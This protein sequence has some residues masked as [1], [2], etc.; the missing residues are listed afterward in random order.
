MESPDR[1]T[2][3][4][5]LDMIDARARRL[6]IGRE[7]FAVAPDVDL[8]TFRRGHRVVVH[9]FRN[10]REAVVLGIA[11][12]DS[13]RT[14]PD[15]SEV[16]AVVAMLTGVLADLSPE[17]SVI[18]CVWLPEDDRYAVRLQIPR[19]AGKAILIPRRVLDRAR[20][21]PSTRRTL[22]NLLHA[23][24]EALRAVRGI[25]E[26]RITWYQSRI[27]GGIWAG[28]RC[29]RCEG[30]LLPDDPVMSQAGTRHHLACP[31]GW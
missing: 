23:A 10:D 31:P 12:G 22:R 4:G 7:E 3:S 21:H 6:R 13:A 19:E 1:F 28:P 20:R 24:V 9:G 18:E 15:E 16:A 11:P 25:S 5:R 8:A 30:P 27:G 26:A 14:H 2:L 17:V 29:A